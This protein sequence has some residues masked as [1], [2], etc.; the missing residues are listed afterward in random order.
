MVLLVLVLTGCGP[1]GVADVPLRRLTP[2]EYN[3]TM[4]DLLG[5]PEHELREEG[6]EE[7]AAWPYAFAPDVPIHGFEGMVEGQLPSPVLVE[8]TQRAANH[9]ARMVPDA[10]YFSACDDDCPRASLHR[11]AQRAWRRP[12]TP[13]EGKRVDALFDEARAA[14]GETVAVQVVASALFQSPQFLFLMEQRDGQTSSWEMASRLSYFLWDSMP[15][16]ELFEAASRDELRTEKQVRKQAER[17]LADPRARQMVVRFHRQWLEL[18]DVYATRQD[19]TTYAETYAPQIVPLLAEEGPQEAE[20]LWSGLL[21][22]MR[23]GMVREAELFVEKTV[24]EGEGT[25]RSLLTDHH[26][27]V[28]E[29]V[30]DEPWSGSTADITQPIEYLQGPPVYQ[31]FLDD[32]NLGFDITWRPVTFDPTQRAG[33]LTLPAVLAAKSHPV[34]PA[35]IL[36][37]TFLLER[38]ACEAPGQPPDGAA[39][40]APADAID[41]E[42]TN[43]VRTEAATAQPGCVECHA[44]LNP[45]GFAMERFDSM[46]GWRETDN[47][48]PVDASGILRLSEDPTEPAFD[49]PVHLAWLLA[50]SSQVTRCYA[51]QWTRYALG[52]ELKPEE[53]AAFQR[54]VHDFS[55]SGTDV[56]QLLVGIAASEVFR[57][58]KGG[59]P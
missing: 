26:G 59:A 52:R 33:V 19:L 29:V 22:A 10:P 31:T 49:G 36:R 2:T 3:H 51:E 1:P 20:E 56:Q 55:A 54:I 8:Q 23:H 4:R 11:L 39:L 45:L 28:S 24:F 46:G 38:I 48:Q 27:Y 6:D 7:D 43:R 44:V 21:I 37:G 35:P 18:D 47:G 34:H 41:A 57:S 32:G 12:L 15:D 58:P 16:A 42:A 13:S 17:M 53:G 25:L 14:H 30:I 5:I 50:N 40:F 9:F